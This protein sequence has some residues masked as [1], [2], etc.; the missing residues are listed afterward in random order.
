M[1]RSSH[2]RFWGLG[3]ELDA[4]LARLR[5]ALDLQLDR[6]A[7]FGGGDRG[8]QGF[9]VGD[10]F[11]IDRGDHVTLPEACFRGRGALGD[12][13]DPPSFRNAL[14]SL[15][16]QGY[17]EDAAPHDLM[18][19]VVN[20]HATAGFPQIYILDPDHNIIEINAARLD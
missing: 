5:I 4:H 15:G 14:E 12:L 19:M 20:R 18:R 17:R 1:E 6:V 2:T 7:R 3:A 13:A 10:G 11:A 8:D 16:S 9:R